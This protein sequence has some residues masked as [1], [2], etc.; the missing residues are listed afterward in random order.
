MRFQ[1]AKARGALELQSAVDLRVFRYPPRFIERGPGRLVRPRTSPGFLGSGQLRQAPAFAGGFLPDL[2]GGR[3]LRANHWTSS[4]G[5][6]QDVSLLGRS[7]TRPMSIAP[8]SR[9]SRPPSGVGCPFGDVD[10]AHVIE[11][12]CVR[13]PE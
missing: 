10:K 9:F 11:R 12:A 6:E 13:E 2:P 1:T 5:G 4:G 8:V 7:T 3:C